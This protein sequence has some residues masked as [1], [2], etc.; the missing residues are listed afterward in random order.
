MRGLIRMRMLL[1]LQMR[2]LTRM[3]LI[4]AMERAGRTPRPHPSLHR[5]TLATSPY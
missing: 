2:I 4:Y 1:P 3:L 5:V